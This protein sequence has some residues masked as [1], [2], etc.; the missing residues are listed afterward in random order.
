MKESISCF[1][2]NILKFDLFAEGIDFHL[3]GKNRNTN[4][5]GV[6]ITLLTIIIT[7]L[8]S[9]NI[10][11]NFLSKTNPTIKISTVNTSKNDT[12]TF[13]PDEFFFSLSVLDFND[14]VLKP[15]LST[16]YEA[17]FQKQYFEE[18]SVNFIRLGP[19]SSCSKNFLE[20]DFIKSSALQSKYLNSSKYLETLLN[21]TNCFPNLTAIPNISYYK[22]ETLNF[23]ISFNK[24]NLIQS[25]II[26]DFYYKD[27]VL[28]GDNFENVSKNEWRL[29]RLSLKKGFNIYDI[30]Y[31]KSVVDIFNPAFIF[32]NRRQSIENNE[33]S[34]YAS[35]IN[36]QLFN[37]FPT[38]PILQIRLNNNHF[39]KITEIRYIT[40][41]EVI[42][43]LGGSFSVFYFVFS[44][45]YSTLIEKI[46]DSDIIN[47]IFSIHSNRKFKDEIYTNNHTNKIIELK[48]TKSNNF[49]QFSE[50]NKECLSNKEKM[51][52]DKYNN[53]I[54]DIKNRDELKHFIL[55]SIIKINYPECDKDLI[56][57]NEK[58][59]NENNNIE[60]NNE[61][62]KKVNKQTNSAQIIPIV[63]GNF[64]ISDSIRNINNLNSSYT[65]NINSNRLGND[66]ANL[67]NKILNKNGE[68]DNSIKDQSK[69][70]DIKIDNAYTTKNIKKSNNMDEETEKKQIK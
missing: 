41:D 33:F 59:Y 61:I 36:T 22:E 34:K 27:Y 48:S 20:N 70:I 67:F 52:K 6:F 43:S 25:D 44:I 13:R 8:S 30:H 3:K 21:T 53:D 31:T 45:I 63:H 42:A 32:E 49:D 5:F 39:K 60:K 18:L 7:F 38:I 66:K 51:F 55:N 14:G 35:L 46:I 62:S 64:E 23:M 65:S 2:T 68:F 17:Y 58:N 26:L 15:V 29:I 54:V 12:L 24:E 19:A 40:L 47:A 28:N 10:I 9:Y 16:Q 4:I 56:L 57:S 50:S 69:H 37:E 11:E 1:K